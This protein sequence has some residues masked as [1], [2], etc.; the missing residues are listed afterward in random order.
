MVF[1]VSLSK[2][3]IKKT[4]IQYALN[5]RNRIK[6]KKRWLFSFMFL[7]IGLSAFSQGEG[8]VA[9]KAY[10]NMLKEL[11]ARS[12]KE[13]SVADI[14]ADYSEYTFLDAREKKEY[15]VSHIKGAIWIGYDDFKMN[16]LKGVEKTDKIIVYCSVGYRSEKVSEKLITG[17][18]K[19]VSNL[20]G[21]IFEWVNQ[22]RPVYDM[23][24]KVTTKV[25]AFDREWGRWLKAGEKV[26]N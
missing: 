10:D 21:S 2:D 3:L 26:Y 18:Y 5:Q 16:R 17:G 14:P 20:Y 6:M 13:V 11:L 24:G 19:N 23:A 7:L 22:G 8:K 12:V 9:S 1:D 25:H 4:G 15:E